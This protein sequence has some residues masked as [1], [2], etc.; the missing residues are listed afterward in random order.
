MGRLKNERLF[1]L[2]TPGQ[3]AP[4]DIGREQFYAEQSRGIRP[5][6]PDPYYTALVSGK[7]AFDFLTSEYRTMYL[8]GEWWGFLLL[9]KDWEGERWVLPF[10]CSWYPSLT[11][12][13]LPMWL[14]KEVKKGRDKI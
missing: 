8:M 3:T 1:Q 13:P 10:L 11:G 9:W 12:R 6:V 2:F 7:K 14:G 4:S 5:E